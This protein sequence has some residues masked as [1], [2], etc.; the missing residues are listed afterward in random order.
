MLVEMTRM[1]PSL[2]ADLLGND[3]KSGSGYIHICDV[4]VDE[5]AERAHEV[6]AEHTSWGTVFRHANRIGRFSHEQMHRLSSEHIDQLTAGVIERAEKKSQ[7]I[8]HNYRSPPS[9]LTLHLRRQSFCSMI[10]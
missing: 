6:L 10:F 1:N 3:F 4:F 5:G 9:T 7:F 2:N 8:F